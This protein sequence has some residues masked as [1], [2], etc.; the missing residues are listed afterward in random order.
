MRLKNSYSWLEKLVSLN[1][2]LLMVPTLVFPFVILT[3]YLKKIERVK[4]LP[5]L[6]DDM[7]V[8]DLSNLYG[9][10]DIEKILKTAYTSSKH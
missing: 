5:D 10:V 6:N 7:D 8:E 1:G 4:P 2:L 3:F 9:T